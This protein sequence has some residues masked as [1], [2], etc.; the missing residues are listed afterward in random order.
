[1]IHTLV[2]DGGFFFSCSITSSHWGN[3]AL[4]PEV[5]LMHGI[6]AR[7]SRHS[8]ATGFKM[9]LLLVVFNQHSVYVVVV[10]VFFERTGVSVA[11][12]GLTV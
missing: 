9:Y 5:Q 6:K 1:M 2:C 12:L 8:L 3:C 10:V 11:L 4:A 7:T